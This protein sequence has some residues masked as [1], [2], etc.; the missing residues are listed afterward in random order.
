MLRTS[1]Q[2]D[3]MFVAMFPLKH[4]TEGIREHCRCWLVGVP[5]IVNAL[6]IVFSY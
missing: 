6:L 2:G 1:A 3:D 5:V 4:P